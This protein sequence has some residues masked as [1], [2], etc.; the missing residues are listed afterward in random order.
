MVIL[1]PSAWSV[2]NKDFLINVASVNGTPIEGADIRLTLQTDSNYQRSGNSNSRGEI[3]FENISEGTYTI[4]IAKSGYVTIIQ[5]V[6]IT[7][8]SSKTFYLRHDGFKIISGQVYRDVNDNK[9]FDTGELGIPSAT[10][11]VTNITTNETFSVIS[12]E[13]GQF[14]IEVPDAQNYNVKVNF[15]QSDYEV[16]TSVT[17]KDTVDYSISIPLIIKGEVYGKLT[18]DVGE[19]IFGIQVF[20]KGT[21]VTYTTTDLGG[22]FR[23]S[24][25]PGTYFVEVEFMDY[26]KFT[27]EPFNL[28]QEEQKEVTIVLSKQKGTLNYEIKTEDGR[29]LTE[30]DAK[31][32]KTGSDTVI[33]EITKANGSVQLVPGVYTLKADAKGYDPSEIDFEITKSGLSKTLTLK[34]ANGSL[35]VSLKNAKGNP[36]NGVSISIDGVQKGSSDNTGVLIVSDLPPKE[37]QVVASSTLYGKVTQIVKVEGETEKEIALVL[38]QNILVQGLPVIIIAAFLIIIAL[39]KMNLKNFNL[40]KLS[41]EKQPIQQMPTQLPP[42]V[43]SQVETNQDVIEESKP[44]PIKKTKLKTK[45]H[46]RGLPKRPSKGN[47]A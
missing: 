20:L 14:R 29:A 22:F 30:V 12:E 4:T 16:P 41:Q 26:E 32:I 24:V 28:E 18:N 38:E 6:D 47:N 34:P 11:K 10:V 44:V 23:F 31:I 25:K 1:I 43:P 8:I 42:Q 15:N 37:Y 5:N 40:P 9:I 46:L 33:Q 13:S 36:I 3:L 45:K 21:S 17:P 39:L 19:P 35:K 7:P 27:T 2:S